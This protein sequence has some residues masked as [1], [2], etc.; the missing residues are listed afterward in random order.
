MAG[1]R[2]DPPPE[3][4]GEAAGIAVGGNHDIAGRHH[5][6]AGLDPPSIIGWADARN[7]GLGTHRNITPAASIEQTLVVE[8]GVQFAR[9]LDDHAAE[10]VIARHLFALPPARH[11]VG[12]GLC[13]CVEYGETL[14]LPLEVFLCPGPDKAPRLFPETFDILFLDYP[15]DQCK[16]VRSVRQQAGNAVGIDVGRLAGEALADIDPAAD[17]TAVARTGAKAEFACF[18]HHRVDA[19][20]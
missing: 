19:V 8:R 5:A 13:G 7:R 4:R 1:N 9:S 6:A 12:A 16:C 3:R 2:Y 15:V 10:V 11:H 18:E 14:R 17:R 20:L